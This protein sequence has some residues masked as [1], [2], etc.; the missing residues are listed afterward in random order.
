MRKIFPLLVVGLCCLA[1]YPRP[2]EALIL[3]APK[4]KFAY[5]DAS[6]KR[7]SAEV[8]DKYYPKKIVRPLAKIDST[9][10]PK[11]RR[12]ATIAQER[13]RALAF[14]MLAF[15]QRSARCCR[16]GEVP[17]ANTFGEA[18]RPGAGEKS[19]LQETPGIRSLPGAGRRG[20]GVWC[21]ARSRSR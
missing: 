15:C 21:Q 3:S 9:I 4:P 6:G 1:F 14:Q 19:R 11:L 12:A 20:V 7:Q 5:T 17:A 18:G 13:A 16:C 10:D 2:A 8:V